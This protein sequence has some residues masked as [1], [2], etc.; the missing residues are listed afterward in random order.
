MVPDFLDFYTLTIVMNNV[1]LDFSKKFLKN[2]QKIFKNDFLSN[3]KKDLETLK[4]IYTC[5]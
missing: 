2:F 5:K 3:F 1:V 4:K